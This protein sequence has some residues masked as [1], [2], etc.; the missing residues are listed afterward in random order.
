MKL[1]YPDE[2]PTAN[3]F[4]SMATHGGNII[5]PMIGG[6]LMEQVSLDSPAYLGSTLYAVLGG[7]YY[8]L[9]KDEAIKNDEIKK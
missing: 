5:A 4:S 1:L 3:S 7:S 2:R 6:R 9:L 8:L